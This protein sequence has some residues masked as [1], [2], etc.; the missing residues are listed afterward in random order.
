MTVQLNE[1]RQ[2]DAPAKR[3]QLKKW[4][5]IEPRASKIN[6]VFLQPEAT[7]GLQENVGANDVAPNRALP[8][9]L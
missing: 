3:G 2:A 8:T 1:T 6:V 9:P 4:C 7:F 5:N